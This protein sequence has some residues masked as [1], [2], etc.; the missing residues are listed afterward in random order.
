MRSETI[1][2]R[3]ERKKWATQPRL[4]LRAYHVPAHDSVQEWPFTRDFASGPVVAAVTDKLVCVRRVTG[5]PQRVDP[6]AGTSDI[7]LLTA[8]LVNIGGE[9]TR[10]L[11]DPALPLAGTIPAPTPMRETLGLGETLAI[12]PSTGPTTVLTRMEEAVALSEFLVSQPGAPIVVLGDGR[13]YPS[14]GTLTI[15]AEDLGYTARTF[16][17]SVTTFTGITRGTR[18]TVPAEHAPGV[19][20]R[21]GEQLRRGQRLTLFLGYA[22]MDEDEYGP[23]VGYVK[24]AIEAIDSP[25]A[26]QTWTL[27]ATDIQRF[28]KRTIFT[29][30][31]PEAPAVLGP[32][33][34]LD[35][36]LQVLTSTGAGVNGAYDVHPAH[37]GAAVP[38]TLVNVETLEFVRDAVLPGL[39]MRFSEIE[40][41]DAKA[42]IEQQLLRPL[43][44]VPWVSQRGRYGVRPQRAPLFLRSALVLPQAVVGS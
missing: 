4:F 21:N 5:N 8:E 44:L 30:A 31:T 41:T 22:P 26:G 32:A 18:G 13:G 28:V 40:A 1:A 42:F 43:N 20:V 34:P 16:D 23:S 6:I 37:M 11:A 39:T 17:G 25:N 9:I 33:H 27:R 15:D 2:Y 10:Y 24:M 29:A 7:G 35:L 14:R 19:L 38:N 36:A 3:T 12:D